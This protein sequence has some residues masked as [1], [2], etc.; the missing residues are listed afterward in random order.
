[1]YGGDFQLL[2]GEVKENVYSGNRSGEF[3]ASAGGR[4]SPSVENGWCL[5]TDNG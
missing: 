4:S 1:L 5:F 2:A 3:S